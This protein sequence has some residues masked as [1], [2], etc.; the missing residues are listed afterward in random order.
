M[1]SIL[2]NSKLLNGPVKFLLLAITVV[3]AAGFPLVFLFYGLNFTDT[4]YMIRSL[5]LNNAVS[6][7]M[8][9]TIHLGRLWEH[10]FNDSI[11]AFRIFSVFLTLCLLIAVVCCF[12]TKD[13]PV[14]IY[15]SAIATSIL[16]YSTSSIAYGYDLLTM[17]L[18]SLTLLFLI[19]FILQR[20][21]WAL[22]ASG[23]VSLILVLARFPNFLVL[24]VT[25][26]LLLTI[27]VLQEKDFEDDGGHRS[28]RL[29][30]KYWLLYISGFLVTSVLFF[31]VFETPSEYFSVLISSLTNME[32]YDHPLYLLISNYLR[33]GFLVIQYI[34]VILLLFAAYWI[35]SEIF[36]WKNKISCSVLILTYFLYL[37]KVNLGNYNWGF[38][39]NL[40]AFCFSLILFLLFRYLKEGNYTRVIVL[41]SVF[42]FAFIPAFGSDTGLLKSSPLLVMFFPLLFSWLFEQSVPVNKKAFFSAILISLVLF[43]VYTRCTW[44]YGDSQKLS[45]LKNVSGNKKL[46]FIKTTSSRTALIEKVLNMISINEDKQEQKIFFGQGG[47]MFYYLLDQEPI[48]NQFFHLQPNDKIALHQ[49]SEIIIKEKRHPLVVVIQGIPDDKSWPGYLYLKETGQKSLPV[50]DEYSCENLEKLLFANNYTLVADDPA[51]NIYKYCAVLK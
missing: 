3:I 46:S 14:I 11:I 23:I 29:T 28:L 9:L 43:G 51:F 34:F 16:L 20:N 32:K 35:M 6:Q 41:F 21:I 26:I 10:W 30:L 33:D 1:C 48:V 25:M 31:I 8:W 2:S 27:A 13:R 42:L 5:S 18:S 36:N 45:E 17:I 4:P 22:I 12:F 24:P 38:R 39:L 40:T 47:Q 44:F 7:Q 49:L 37:H 50:T 19:S 15:F